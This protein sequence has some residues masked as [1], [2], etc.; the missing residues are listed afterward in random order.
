MNNSFKTTNEAYIPALRFHW[1]TRFYDIFIGLTTREPLV[2]NTLIHQAKL[3]NDYKVLDV[4]CG[5][6]TLACWIK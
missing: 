1:L 2:K 3:A 6:G 5:T 4:G